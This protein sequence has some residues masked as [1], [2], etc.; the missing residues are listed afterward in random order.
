[1]RKRSISSPVGARFTLRAE[2]ATPCRPRRV[3]HQEAS[4]S[5]ASIEQERDWRY[6]LYF[7]GVFSECLEPLIPEAIDVLRLLAPFDMGKLL[8]DLLAHQS[9]VLSV[10]DNSRDA[11]FS[12]LSERV[13]S[14]VE[15]NIGRIEVVCLHCRS[16]DVVQGGLT[17]SMLSCLCCV[18]KPRQHKRLRRLTLQIRTVQQAPRSVLSQPRIDDVDLESQEDFRIKPRSGPAELGTVKAWCAAIGIG[19]GGGLCGPKILRVTRRGEGRSNPL[20]P[21]RVCNLG[22]AASSS[23]VIWQPAGHRAAFYR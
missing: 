15:L 18:T 4:K 8:G 6:S 13:W 22:V 10:V 20:Q 5:T 23:I 12:R 1:V 2:S 16:A 11:V 9:I 7:E 14:S 3:Q 17:R 21:C 19:V